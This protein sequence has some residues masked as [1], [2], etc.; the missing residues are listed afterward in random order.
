[1]SKDI[2][3]IKNL[4]I[5]YEKNCV[6]K[7]INLNIPEKQITAIIGPSGCGKTTLLKCLNRMI[8][9]ESDVKITGEVIFDDVDI[10]D[11]KIDVTSLRKKLGFIAQTPNPLPMSIYDNIAYGPKIHGKK[12]KK[13]LN[14]I[15]ER[16]LQASGLWN[17]VS[18]RLKQPATKLSIGQ[19]QRLCIARAIA[20]EPQVLLCDEPTSALD[21]ISTRHVEDQ[22]LSLKNDYTTVFVTHMLRQARKIADYAVFIYMGEIIEHGPAKEIFTKPREKRT[23]AYLENEVDYV[24]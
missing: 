14:Q 18:S 2:I 5:Y 16:C 21:P 12:D 4:N 3:T 22:L 10:L 13:E 19:Q 8:D 20:V 9:L 7:N 23:K 6:L 17:E 15:V 1:M 11:K 24:I